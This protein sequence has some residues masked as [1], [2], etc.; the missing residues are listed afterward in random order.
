MQYA[1]SGIID[2][3]KKDA[4]YKI[5]IDVG[6]DRVWRTK[7]KFMIVIDVYIDEG[8]EYSPSAPIVGLDVV[9]NGV[10]CTR[11]FSPSAMEWIPTAFE[12]LS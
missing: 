10:F 3:F 6:F 12:R 9:I 11:F 8:K 2:F 5:C 7:D 4:M 1:T